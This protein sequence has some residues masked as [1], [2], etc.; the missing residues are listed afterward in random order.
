MLPKKERLSR[1]EFN[2]FI[3]SGKKISSPSFQ[4]IHAKSVTFHASVVIPK[5]V[6][7]RAVRRNK[8][9]RQMYDIVRRNK[10]GGMR[11]I[12][13]FIARNGI[14]RRSYQEIKNEIE[15]SIEGATA[16]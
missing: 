11:G 12:F 8:L 15:K 16:Q 7:R 9:R 4:L 6:E 14:E 5:K 1:S 3:F 2:R 10:K 13:I